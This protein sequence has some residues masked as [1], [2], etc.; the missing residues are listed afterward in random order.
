MG[1]G[2]WLTATSV[3]ELNK[4][5]VEFWTVR[6]ISPSLWM[7]VFQKYLSMYAIYVFMHIFKP[8]DKPFIKNQAILYPKSFSSSM[9]EVAR[10]L[11]SAIWKHCCLHWSFF[12]S[13]FFYLSILWFNSLSYYLRFMTIYYIMISYA[14]QY[15]CRSLSTYSI[16]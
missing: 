2:V 9:A 10:L 11:R 15:F 13:Y 8:H 6:R 5:N 1:E 4:E 14:T 3:T 16:N 12:N 7:S